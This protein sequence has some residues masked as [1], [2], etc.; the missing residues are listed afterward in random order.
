MHE[1]Q[2]LTN[3][4]RAKE[5]GPGAWPGQTGT[6]SF[7]LML[8]ERGLKGEEAVRAYIAGVGLRVRNAG[9]QHGFPQQVLVHL[10]ALLG[11][12]ELHIR[13]HQIRGKGHCGEDNFS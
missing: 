11:G 5:V 4:K 8:T 7:M 1:Q 12:D 3:R 6:G 2:L 10:L 13:A 9:T